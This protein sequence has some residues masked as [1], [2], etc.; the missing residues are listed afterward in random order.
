MSNDE[1]NSLI[2]WDEADMS[3][4]VS[5]NVSVSHPHLQLLVTQEA[6]KDGTV[7]KPVSNDEGDSLI[8]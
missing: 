2:N 1:S 6:W 7:G 8:N 5:P 3:L 4:S